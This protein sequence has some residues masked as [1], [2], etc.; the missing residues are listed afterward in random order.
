MPNADR[1]I[2]ELFRIASEE[3]VD[4]DA[5]ANLLEETK[6][7]V[8]AK[9]M[10]AEGDIPVSRAEMRV[11]AS[12]T[13]REHIEKMVDARANANLLKVRVDY[14]KMRFSE[15]NAADANARAERRIS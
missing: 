14:L 4:A 13:W 11:K 1:P 9:L 3:W 15:W 2:S 8:L 12:D 6:S 5:A 10:M 7:A